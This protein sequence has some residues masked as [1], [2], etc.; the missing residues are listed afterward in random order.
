MTKC[1]LCGSS[2]F[3]GFWSETHLWSCDNCGVVFQSPQGEFD[4]SDYN[5][6]HRKEG[7]EKRI[8]Q[9]SLDVENIVK[10]KDSGDFL[11]VGCGD[12]TFLN[13][14][15]SE[16]YSKDG[17]D[18]RGAYRVGS[19][20]EYSFDKKYDIVHM[21]GTIE[22]LSKPNDYIAKANDVLKDNGL[23]VLSHVPNVDNYPKMKR[24]IIE[25]EHLFYFNV[26]SM[27]FLL[28]KHGFRILD[29]L[30]PFY[31]TP[32]ENDSNAFFMNVLSVYAV[33]I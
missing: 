26:K 2:S 13:V 21:R 12:G 11:D 20:P 24:L 31:G 1:L 5:V 33:K 29:I 7:R 32:Y 6:K 14:L 17:I 4:Y 19:F 15:P 16:R 9:Y 25:D 8:Q 3:Y 27:N 22:H 23:L 28:E 30:F 18:V 10:F